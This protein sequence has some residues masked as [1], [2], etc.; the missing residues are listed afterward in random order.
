MPNV[1]IKFIP[2]KKKVI[3]KIIDED[4]V[5]ASFTLKAK[6][7]FDGN[8][9]IYDH[10]DIDIILM[11]EQKKVVTFKK[12]DVNGDIAYGASDRLF[13]YLASR[14]VVSLNSVQGSN[15]SNSYE[16]VISGTSIKIPIKIVM[17]TISKW[18]EKER[19]YFEYGEDYEDLMKDRLL[20]PDDEES[21]ELGEVPQDKS[22][23]SIVP[24]YYRSPYWMSYILEQV[25]E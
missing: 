2:S 8:I 11:P 9:I 6:K 5:L 25:E 12:D 10:A 24:G 21:T 7:T 13:K 4:E 23:G 1:R 14:G 19:P 20:E 17:L 22:K 16:A 18:I 15:T 3:L